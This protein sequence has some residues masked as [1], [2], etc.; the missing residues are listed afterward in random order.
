MYRYR[1][2]GVKNSTVVVAAVLTG[3]TAAKV[4]PTAHTADAAVHSAA[5]RLT[6]G[7]AA[8]GGTP[9]SNEALGKQL[10]ADGYGWTAANGQWYCL[11]RLW[12]QESGWSN[13]ADTR[14]TG[15]GGD[16]PGSPVWAY[17]IAQAR[18]A[19]KYPLAGRS[20]DIGG[21]SDPP[22]QIRWGLRYI[23]VVYGSP[24]AAWGHEV[25]HRWY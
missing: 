5:A 19:W 12:M 9:S 20:P 16:H 15:A 14:V 10:A 6:A 11:Y 21:W 18:P 17:G 13:T 1:R 23:D 24:C 3:L 22:T 7:H 25:T 2:L 4:Y 8:Q